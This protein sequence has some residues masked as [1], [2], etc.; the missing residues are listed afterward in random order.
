M[1]L[2]ADNRPY[3]ILYACTV[4]II[5]IIIIVRIR[6]KIKGRVGSVSAK[7]KI[8]LYIYDTYYP[9]TVTSHFTS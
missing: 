1:G 5:I 9:D 6:I 3:F 7:N 2:F 4:Y 8:R